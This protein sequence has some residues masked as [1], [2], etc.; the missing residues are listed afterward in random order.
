MPLRPVF[1]EIPAYYLE[2]QEWGSGSVDQL[3]YMPC[4][5]ILVDSLEYTVNEARGLMWDTTIKAAS[6]QMAWIEAAERIVSPIASY[7]RTQNEEVLWDDMDKFHSLY[8]PDPGKETVSVH[9]EVQPVDETKPGYADY[10]LLDP[11]C[12]GCPGGDFHEWVAERVS[13]VGAGCI[14][15][16]SVCQCCGLREIAQPRDRISTWLV[17]YRTRQ[18]YFR[19]LAQARSVEIPSWHSRRVI[20]TSDPGLHR[21]LSLRYELPDDWPYDYKYR[22]DHTSDIEPLVEGYTVPFGYFD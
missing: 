2:G 1:N 8:V 16:V 4:R 20:L 13:Q 22:A 3:P 5:G 19:V 6:P 12:P 18:R 17:A 11:E 7:S 10:L 14:E 9:L 21:L 15:I